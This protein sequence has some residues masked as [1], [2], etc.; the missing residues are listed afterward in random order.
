[1]KKSFLK[2]FAAAAVIAALPLAACADG[3]NMKTTKD[4][5]VQITN[6]D[7]S[8]N[9]CPDDNCPDD[10]CPNDDCPNDDCPDDNCQDDG[11]PDGN[12]PDGG[13][14]NG[15]AKK[16]KRAVFPRRRLTDRRKL[17]VPPKKPI[18]PPEDDVIAPDPPVD[19][20]KPRN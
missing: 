7:G 8:R 1:M 9:G 20:E 16:H 5:D 11:C 3:E 19:D 15:E 14:D 2:L 13:K 12:C 18:E 17:P 6:P 10:D 4:D